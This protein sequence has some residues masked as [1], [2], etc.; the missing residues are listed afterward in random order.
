MTVK[1]Y[2]MKDADKVEH[3]FDPKKPV[4]IC[5]YGVEG[6]GW[7]MGFSQTIRGEERGH[8]FGGLFVPEIEPVEW[9]GGNIAFGEATHK[10]FAEAFSEVYGVEPVIER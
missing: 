6:I 5:F 4:R 8:V 7:G 3:L 2:G 10:R 1:P 9:K